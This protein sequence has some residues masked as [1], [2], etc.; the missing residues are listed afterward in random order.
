MK[1][2]LALLLVLLCGTAFATE[3]GR[4]TTPAERQRGCVWADKFESQALVEENGGTVT[5]SPTFTVNSGV[6][7]DGTSDYLTFNLL[8]NEVN[9]DLI[10]FVVEFTPHFSDDGADRVLYDTTNANGGRCLLYKASNDSLLFYA[11]NTTIDTITWANY[12]AYWLE[13]QRN[14][15]V[16]VADSGDSY[17]YL[18]GTAITSADPSAFTEGS[19]STLY[20]GVSNS[21]AGKFDGEI[22]SVKILHAKLTAAEAQDFYD[23]STYT[24]ENSATAHW[25]MRA[26][27]HDPTNDDL[28]R[29]VGA[30]EELLGSVGDFESWQ[31]SHANCTDCP[32]GVLCDCT[33]GD[34]VQESSIVYTGSTSVEMQTA[35]AYVPY[36]IQY[37]TWEANKCYQ[38]S[39]CYYGNDG[40]EDVLFGVGRLDLADTYDPSSDTW[41]A[42]ITGMNITNAPASWTCE[43]MFVNVGATEK[44]AGNAYGWGIMATSANGT[45]IYVDNV[46]VKEFADCLLGTSSPV[47]IADRHGYTF[48]GAA[49]RFSDSG[50]NFNPSGDFSVVVQFKPDTVN[51]SIDRLVGKWLA[52]GDEYGWVLYRFS[53]ILYFDVSD[54]GTTD[55]GHYTSVTKDALV[56]NQPGIAIGTYQYA[57]DGTSLMS[58]YL[59]DL[60]AATSSTANGPVHASTSSLVVADDATTGSPWDGEIED[61][62]FFDGT[63][64]T[65]LQAEDIKHTLKQRRNDP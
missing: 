43:S 6:E 12:S 38:V 52:A 33:L 22:H 17:L 26:Q 19:E 23:H 55:G 29:S 32:T 44:P 59:D 35:Y 7:L 37:K 60:P 61:V 42:P 57:G 21:A 54:D 45:A 5:G 51:A 63:A 65:P 4:Y 9:N 24:Y 34:I 3:L 50:G 62:I 48:D 14:V 36:I 39:W 49:D 8:G 16:A 28:T 13:N 53:T 10:T 46:R 2:A 64:L 56:A 25:R 15:I 11:G 31:G 41:T 58:L 1:R 47:K 27:D 30:Y 40:T 18:N 20:V